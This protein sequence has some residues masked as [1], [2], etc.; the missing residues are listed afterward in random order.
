MTG[1]VVAG[2]LAAAVVR[3]RRRLELVARAE[4]ELRG[5]LTAF[6]LAAERV[7]RCGDARSLAGAL[8]AELLRAQVALADLKAARRSRR[9]AARRECDSFPIGELARASLAA[10]AP[11]AAL[12]WS[13]GDVQVHGDRRRV[14]QALGNLLANAVEHGAGGVRLRAA[15]DGARLRL[16]V[17]NERRGRGIA[18]ATAAAQDSGGSLAVAT[19][20]LPVAV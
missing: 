13:A 2:L 14:A 11:D 9:S 18:I 16:E 15:R 5:P 10:W 6:A 19:L 1:W 17:V 12:E 7:R 3:L 4:H 20:E 8:D